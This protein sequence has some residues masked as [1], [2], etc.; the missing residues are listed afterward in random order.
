MSSN[1]HVW[2]MFIKPEEIKE[3]L[4]S[5]SLAWQ[6]HKVSSSN[7]SIPRMLRYLRKKAK[8]EWAF[9][10]L[11]KKFWLVESSDMIILYAGL[12]Q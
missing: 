7:V 5:N 4:A 10:D 9:Q 12:C 8:G 3:L 2:K 11:G 6:A 1:L